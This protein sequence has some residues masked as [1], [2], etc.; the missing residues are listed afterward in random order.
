MNFKVKFGIKSKS[1]VVIFETNYTN[2]T[3]GNLSKK[4]IKVFFLQGQIGDNILLGD[5]GKSFNHNCETP[6]DLLDYHRLATDPARDRS[7][8]TF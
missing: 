1:L 5:M 3:P 2:N 6:V 7:N 4:I 8:P